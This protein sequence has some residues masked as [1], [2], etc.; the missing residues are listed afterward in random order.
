MSELKVRRATEADLPELVSF[1]LAQV[2]ESEGAIKSEEV[3]TLG[4]KRALADEKLAIYWVLVNAA[5]KPVGAASVTREWSDW[6]A[7]YYWWMQSLYVM[8]TSRGKNDMALL[9][10]AIK[11]EMMRQEG[12]ELRIYVNKDNQA[13]KAAYG[14][15]NFYL[16]VYEVMVHEEEE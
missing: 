9:I 2:K 4:I 8:P 11:A 7:G 15:S 5:D 12:L 10:D 16:S 6:N 3:V 1:V 13:A 14:R